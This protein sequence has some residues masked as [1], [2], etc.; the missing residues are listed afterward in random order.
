MTLDR[1]SVNQSYY[2]LLGVPRNA[3]EITL[4]KAFRTL[5]KS[6]HPDTTTL[7]PEEATFRFREVREAYELLSDPER[8]QQY[9]AVLNEQASSQKKSASDSLTTKTDVF[10]SHQ[11][12]GIRRPL[13]G[14]EL[15]AL[16][17]LVGVLLISLLLGLVFASAH[18]GDLQVRPSWLSVEQ[19]IDQ[20]KSQE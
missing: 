16:M 5:S 11:D 10:V 6:F 12:V 13:S 17:L 20:V 19:S 4:H 7:P 18:G 3:N 2:E 15:F 14:G 8:R 9:D 1:T